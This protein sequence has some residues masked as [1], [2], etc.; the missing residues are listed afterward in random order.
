MWAWVLADIRAVSAA[1]F[2]AGSPDGWRKRSAGLLLTI[3]SFCSGAGLVHA[4]SDSSLQQDQAHAAVQRI[5][6]MV[7]QGHLSMDIDIEMSLSH[8]MTEALR[9]GVPLTFTIEVQIDQPRWWWFDKVLVDARLT[10]RVSFN[11]LTRQWRVSIGDLGLVVASYDEAL[12][13]VR[14]VRGWEVAPMDRFESGTDYKGQVRIMLD[15]TQLSRPM[16]LDANK[17]SDWTLIS[18]WRE[19]EFSVGRQGAGS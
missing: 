7:H 19:F 8:A 13:L 14:R 1:L 16:Q 5:E 12:D 17:R 6:P 18:P 9:R 15:A 10:R 3:L 2:L 4:Q 11:T